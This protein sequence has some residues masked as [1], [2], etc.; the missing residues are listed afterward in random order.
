MRPPPI[1]PPLRCSP[2]AVAFL[3]ATPT[4]LGSVPCYGGYSARA[5]PP[6]AG[7]Q[8]PSPQQTFSLQWFPPI[9][10]GPGGLIFFISSAPSSL[11]LLFFLT[12]ISFDPHQ[13]VLGCLKNNKLGDTTQIEEDRAAV[14][15]LTHV[16]GGAS[17]PRSPA[18]SLRTP[19]PWLIPCGGSNNARAKR[20]APAHL[21]QAAAPT[22]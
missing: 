8:S 17:P 19:G 15:S 21:W 3:L 16:Q 4:W 12:A 22:S 2:T 5:S 14:R 13:S 10:G 9:R 11:F 6:I 7:G 1:A 20:S 18:G